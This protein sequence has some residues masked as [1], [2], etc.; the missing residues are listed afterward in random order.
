ME[1]FSES[2]ADPRRMYERHPY[3]PFIIIA[4][5][6]SSPFFFTNS[7]DAPLHEQVW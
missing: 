4:M 6:L 3:F 2:F 5:I 1:E 7:V